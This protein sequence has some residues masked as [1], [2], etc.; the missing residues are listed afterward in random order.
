M[1]DSEECEDIEVDCPEC[2]GEMIEGMCM[3]C[4]YFEE[5]YL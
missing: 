5:D 4:G 2:G 1:G 3:D